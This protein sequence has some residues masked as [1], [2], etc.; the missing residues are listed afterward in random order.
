M[1][2]TTAAI[3]ADIL[4]VR[5]ALAEALGMKADEV[6]VN[7]QRIVYNNAPRIKELRLRLQ[8]LTQERAGAAGMKRTKA[9]LARV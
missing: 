4:I 7:D 8:E 5:T 1:A 6:E 2:R 3:D 9:R